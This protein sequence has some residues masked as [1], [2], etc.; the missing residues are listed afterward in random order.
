[1]DEQDNIPKRQYKWPW[2]L[3]AAVILFFVLTI[4]WMSFAVHREE[5]ERGFSTPAQTNR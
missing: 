1:M 3:L 2:F 5:Q 4:I